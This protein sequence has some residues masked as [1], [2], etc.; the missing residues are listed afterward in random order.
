M[1]TKDKTKK[2][3]EEL[4]LE[5]RKVTRV[6]TWWRQM[7]FRAIVVVWNRKGKIGL[8]VSKWPDVTSAIQKASREAYKTMFTV[9]LTKANT[10]PYR[11]EYKYKSCIVRLL[12]ASQGTW[13][14]AW[15]SVRSV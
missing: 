12:P 11:S 5:V 8:W 10:V 4:L 6:T 3:F 14:K 15:S 9:P 1:R 7:S 2:E 13:V